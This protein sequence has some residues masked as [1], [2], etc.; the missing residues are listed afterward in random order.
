[1]ESIFFG[2]N[3]Y[4]D[5]PCVLLTVSWESEESGL[6]GIDR[7]S[8]ASRWRVIS[9]RLTSNHIAIARVSDALSEAV[10]SDAA[11]VTDLVLA[12]VHLFL[13]RIGAPTA[14]VEKIPPP[15]AEWPRSLHITFTYDDSLIAEAA[16]R[17][18]CDLAEFLVDGNPFNGNDAVNNDFVDRLD[19]LRLR[20]QSRLRS[21][22]AQALSTIAASRNVP[23]IRYG[24]WPFQPAEGD[25]ESAVLKRFAF[26]QGIHQLQLSDALVL[27]VAYELL[28]DR[29]AMNRHLAS[30]G[31]PVPTTEQE[32]TQINST[33]RAVRAAERLGYPVAL[34]TRQVVEAG[35]VIT[36]LRNAEE[37]AAAYGRLAAKHRYVVVERHVTGEAFQLLVVAGEVK[38]ACQRR[39]LDVVGDGTR[40]IADLISAHVHVDGPAMVPQIHIDALQARLREDLKAKGFDPDSVLPGGEE[41]RVQNGADALTIGPQAD[42]L[43]ELSLYADVLMLACDAASSLKLAAAAVDII[44]D[45]AEGRLVPA[46]A[47]VVA[48][49]PNPDLAFHRRVDEHLPLDTAS[50]YLDALMPPPSDH[51]IPV[52]AVT[53]TNGKTTTCFM[54][55]HILRTTGRITGL[56]ST[57]GFYIDG[58]RRKR[59]VHSGISG[60]FQVFT[61]PHVDAAIL[62]TSRGTLLKHGLAFDRCAVAACT[63]VTEDHIG[64]DGIKTL[65]Q[66]ARVKRTVVEAARE[67]V[68]LNGE[69]PNCLAMLTHCKAAQAYLVFSSNDVSQIERHVSEGRRVIVLKEADEGQNIVVRDASGETLLTPVSTIPATWNGAAVHNVQNA[70]FA[71]GLAL[72]LGVKPSVMRDALSRFST[73]IEQLPGRLNRYEGLDFDVILDFAHNAHGYAALRDCLLK[74]PIKGKRTL[75]ACAPDRQRDEERQAVAQVLAG[76]FDTIICRGTVR[77]DG[78]LVTETAQALRDALVKSGVAESS[79]WVEPELQDALQHALLAAGPG[80]LIAVSALARYQQLWDQLE[81]FR[82]GNLL[83]HSRQSGW[84]ADA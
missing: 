20:H 53:G 58:E 81:A 73:S 3:H 71:I 80:D 4:M 56:A 27:P 42:A 36:D 48:V 14:R 69:D 7:L 83:E 41:L 54:L 45:R 77:R 37:V 32:F 34:K 62:E 60:A 49:N 44:V 15:S 24:L 47:T 43:E 22:S 51:R 68:V 21:M 33:R 1:M 9:D 74:L 57:D 55:E 50:R 52:A 5:H 13:D 12:L 72:G 35:G 82:D 6:S 70:M 25:A 8:C 18:V 29:L 17:V 61:N 78:T 11:Y 64:E 59:G 28:G 66:L 63:N 31:L 84:A 39:P 79:V 65:R 40:R 23:E 38:A 75:I 10:D 46:T 19:S 2:R 67:A 26:G 16:A 30:A 76:A